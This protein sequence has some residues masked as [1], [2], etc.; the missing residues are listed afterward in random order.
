[1]TSLEKVQQAIDALREAEERLR[2]DHLQA[3]VAAARV[4]RK[5]DDILAKLDEQAPRS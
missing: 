4:E 3:A 2:K 1:M 5:I